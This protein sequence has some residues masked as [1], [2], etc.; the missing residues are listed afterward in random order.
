MAV[1]IGNGPAD[2]PKA[3]FEYVETRVWE[4]FPAD[5]TVPAETGPGRHIRF[6]T[7]GRG[8][9]RTVVINDARGCP[10][11]TDE[12]D[13]AL[14]PFDGPLS[15][16]PDA[17]RRQILQ[18]PLPPKVVPDVFG[19]VADFYS[20][21]FVPQTTRQGVLRMLARVPGITVQT[22]V[23]DRTGRAGFAVMWTYQPAAPFTVTKTLIFDALAGQ[24]LS[25][26]SRAHRR[27]DATT[28]PQPTDEY[29][30]FVLFVASTYTPD[31]R[32]PAV[33]CTT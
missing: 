18:E 16:D 31:T 9:S 14:G 10:P 7:T 27:P 1:G 32:T 3:M 29:E 21:R 2:P 15:S 12:S 24:L 11:E 22:G 5:P 17:V 25:S 33:T 13:E 8:V 6:W 26:H 20:D 4:S 19:Q 23:T 28:P 30:I